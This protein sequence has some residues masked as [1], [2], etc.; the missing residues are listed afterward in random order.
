MPGALDAANTAAGA[1]TSAEN[2]AI[3]RRPQMMQSLLADALQAGSCV[4]K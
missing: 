3:N 4:T 1:A 2:T